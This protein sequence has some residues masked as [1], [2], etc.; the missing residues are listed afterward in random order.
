MRV[1]ITGGAG[2]IGSHLVKGFLE[3]GYN[4]RVIDNFSTGKEENIQPFLNDIE[5]LR[6]DICNTETIHEAMDGIDYVLHHAAFKSVPKSLEQP[7]A[8]NEIN[9][10]GTLNVL[11]TA[12]KAKVKRVVYASSS[13]IYG[14]CDNFPQREDFIP[15]PIS[16]YAVTKLTGELYGYAFSKTYGLEV[17]SLRYFNVFG[18]RQ[19]PKSKYSAVIPTF[20]SRMLSGINPVIEGDGKQSR[21]F[22][23]I[24]NVVAANLAAVKAKELSGE[25]IN[26]ACGVAH[27]I[28][29]IVA[30]LNK[31]LSRE[32]NPEFVTAR[33]GDIVKSM[34]DVTKMKQLLNLSPHVGIR[35]GLK[36]TLEWFLSY[37]EI[38]GKL[39]QVD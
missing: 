13:S 3:L 11:T 22:T 21:D 12:K 32:F 10:C 30:I 9:V 28:L 4:V 7:E 15:K 23:Y 2:F 34:A 14:N 31:L 6:G 24:D 39:I 1:L 20:I 35:E 19:D 25:T 8:V 36:K 26:V 38:R 5:L 17:V 16:P 33:K 29:D 18:P 37:H 27:S